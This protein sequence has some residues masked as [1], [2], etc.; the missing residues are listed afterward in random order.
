[1]LAQAVER[2]A[3]ITHD[4]AF[5]PPLMQALDDYHDWLASNRVPGDDRLMVI[6]S[7]HESG[8]ERSPTYDRALGLDRTAGRW[9]RG[10]R[11]RSID[12]RHQLAHYDS[13][14]MLSDSRFYVKD[15]VVN[16]LYADSLATMARLHRA[17]GSPDVA[18][19]YAE[20]AAIVSASIMTKMLDRA[21]GGFFSLVGADELRSEPRT[22]G[23]L[24]PLILE[25][26]PAAVAEEIVER[27]LRSAREFWLRYPIPSV[28]AN[29]DT[30]T[31]REERLPWR[32]P[33]WVYANWL[34]WRGLRLHGF[35][36]LAEQIASRTIGMVAEAG[37]WEFYNPL[38]GEGMG[39]KDFGW[40]ALALDMASTS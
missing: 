34:V 40:S 30:F 22:V 2:V 6:V 20:S 14:R 28:A 12:T 10:W 1:M 38:T 24:V 37:L 31:P 39:K 7:P 17:Q 4:A 5:A 32:G 35:N 19:A 18:A 13:K 8:M 11:D 9:L 16:A 23:S 36:E 25:G 15:A 21:K 29:E 27:H 33:T 3:Q 26:V